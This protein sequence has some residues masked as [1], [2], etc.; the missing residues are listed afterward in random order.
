MCAD[1]LAGDGQNVLSAVCFANSLE[2]AYTSST[3]TSSSEFDLS[4]LLFA[5]DARLRTFNSG[6]SCGLAL[7]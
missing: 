7:E 5:D 2:A 4:D 3:D 1:T 6:Y